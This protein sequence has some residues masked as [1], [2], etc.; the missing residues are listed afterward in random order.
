MIDPLFF[1]KNSTTRRFDLILKFIL[2]GVNGGRRMDALMHH[3]SLYVRII[4]M[5]NQYFHSLFDT[6]VTLTTL[7]SHNFTQIMN[8]VA[9]VLHPN[10]I[11]MG[12]KS[13]RWWPFY[14]YRRTS[15]SSSSSEPNCFHADHSS[16]QHRVHIFAA[17]PVKSDC[18]MNVPDEFSG[19]LISWHSKTCLLIDLHHPPSWKG[20]CC[21]W[22][23]QRCH[24]LIF[25]WNKLRGILFFALLR[26]ERKV[27]NN[28]AKKDGWV[29]G[30]D[31]HGF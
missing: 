21:L 8:Q 19:G 14:Y 2:C 23:F 13:N 28:E 20:S 5:I 6:A 3:H 9:P 24:I 29:V 22:W 7:C 10:E 31:S 25:Y 17:V 15:G 1:S 11:R 12:P 30:S 26:L 16:L 4:D 18:E 27:W